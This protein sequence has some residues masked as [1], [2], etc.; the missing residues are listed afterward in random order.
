MLSEEQIKEFQALYKKNFGE[1][2]SSEE[3]A[4]SARRLLMLVKICR[5]GWIEEYK[6]KERLKESP[7]GLLLEKMTYCAVCGPLGYPEQV[8]YD[9]W[10]IKCLTCQAAVDKKIIPGNVAKDQDGWYSQS[11]LEYRFNI[12]RHTMKK[13]IKQGILKPRIIPD[14][15][16]NPHA[17]LFL[18]KDNK[19]VL[20]P[21]NLTEPQR[22][23]EIKDGKEW[24][25]TEPW[26]KFFDPHKHLKGYKIMDHLR[27]VKDEE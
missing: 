26:Y 21:K 15:T 6:R 10:G 13:F 2:I 24:S 16:G 4:D 20:P 8:W 12:D 17:Y 11:D 22:V 18:L 19:D 9:K 1:E 25:H 27:V 5:D 7:K 23:I 3:A 14:S